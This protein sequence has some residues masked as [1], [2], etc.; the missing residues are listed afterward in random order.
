MGREEMSSRNTH[1]LWYILWFSPMSFRSHVERH[2][3]SPLLTQRADITNA[4]F[5]ACSFS[6]AAVMNHHSLIGSSE[7]HECIPSPFCRSEVWDGL[8]GLSAAV[9]RRLKSR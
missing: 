6:V 1:H 3:D 5:F 7:R 4:G 8:A 2:L 9:F